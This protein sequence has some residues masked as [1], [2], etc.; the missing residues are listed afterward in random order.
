MRFHT[1]CP[2]RL[3]PAHLRLNIISLDI[4]VDAILRGLR[5]GNALKFHVESGDILSEHTVIVLGSVETPVVNSQSSAPEVEIRFQI[6]TVD[7]ETADTGEQPR[8]SWR[9]WLLTPGHGGWK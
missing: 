9:L 3:K 6:V 5:L 2:E 4:E 1:T 8:V 7:D